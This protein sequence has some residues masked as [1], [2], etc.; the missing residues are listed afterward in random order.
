MVKMLFIPADGSKPFEVVDISED[1]DTGISQ[2]RDYL[3]G[4]LEAA[5]VPVPDVTLW[6]D[7]EGKLKDN[8]VN[9]RA[10]NLWG[11]LWGGGTLTDVL[12]G[13]VLLS[14]GVDPE[15]N[16]LSV[17][18]AVLHAMDAVKENHGA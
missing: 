3:G 10:T 11:E 6:C 12:V 17:P 5:P 16:T 18:D 1:I 13:N 15:G 14:G 7:E 2:M 9:V 8:V 4:Y